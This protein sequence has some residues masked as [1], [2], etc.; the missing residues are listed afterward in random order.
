MNEKLKRAQS[1]V[2]TSEGRPDLDFYP[3]PP[4]ATRALL[5]HVPMAGTCWE[6]G[7]GSGW[8]SEVL[9]KH[10][11]D[12]YSTDIQPRGY[13]DPEPL[14]FLAAD[15]AGVE[16]DWVVTNPPYVDAL[17]FVTQALKVA[18]VGVA[19]LVKLA[20]FEGARRWEALKGR[21]PCESYVFTVRPKF[22]REGAEMKNGGM[23]AFQWLVWKAPY[24]RED[25]TVVRHILGGE[26]SWPER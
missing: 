1:L 23:I 18:R 19:M 20:F 15:L 16:F 7:C 14:D 17:G 13:G 8:M 3:T 24:E 12:V 10:G 5:H 26:D 4:W 25:Y 9:I 11:L 22:T 21:Y 2:G 6:P